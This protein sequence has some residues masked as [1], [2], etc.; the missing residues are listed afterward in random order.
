MDMPTTVAASP[1]RLDPDG[2]GHSA[3]R[4]RWAS[5]RLDGMASPPARA[6]LALLL[7]AVGA[8]IVYLRLGMP[9]NTGID[10]ANITQVYARNI[11]QGHGYVYTPGHERV[12]GSTSLLWTAINSVFFLASHRP[13]TGILVATFL[14]TALSLF[15]QFTLAGTL[16]SAL[17]LS[18]AWIYGAVVLWL[19]CLP[20]YFAWAVLT[21]MDFA[22][23]SFVVCAFATVLALDVTGR[24]NRRAALGLT[25]GL[26]VVASAARPEALGVVPVLLALGCVAKAAMQGWRSA[27]RAQVPPLL[28][29]ASSFAALSVFRL[30]YFGYPLPNTYYAKV[31]SNLLDNLLSGAKYLFRYLAQTPALIGAT[32]VAVAFCVCAWRL[33]RRQATRDLATSIVFVTSGTVI[34]GMA[35]A[36]LAGGDHFAGFRFFQAYAP[37]MIFSIVYLAAHVLARL[38][39]ESRRRLRPAY[40]LPVVVLAAV[41]QQLNFNIRGDQLGP[42]FETA[43]QGRL[44]G[45]ALNE[46][47][48]SDPPPLGVLA[49]GGVA[50]TYNGRVLDLLGLNWTTMAH[51]SGRRTGYVGHS[52]FD[53]Q[54][55]WSSPPAILGPD[56]WRSRVRPCVTEELDFML[57]GLLATERFRELYSPGIAETSRARILAYFRKDLPEASPSAGRIRLVSWDDV[58]F[59]E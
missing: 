26:A 7:C 22:L 27:I 40:L 11:A 1:D 16:A 33:A 42:E 39:R 50:L 36:V 25:C 47:L 4:G 51:A 19:L 54:V 55:F 30:I 37:L 12:E 56:I 17:G 10:D 24:L 14:I 35:A 6:I 3:G 13:E 44:T 29:T 28:V 57:K 15:C 45:E 9:P 48:G 43:E 52:A 58:G 20:A 34:F 49:A 46:V 5:Y 59:C 31:S 41:A 23:W 53:E 38:S 2:G 32:C 21:L 18:A 8:A